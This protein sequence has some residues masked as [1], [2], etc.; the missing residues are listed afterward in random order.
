MSTPGAKILVI[1]RHHTPELCGEMANSRS[2]KG[3]YKMTV[4]SYAKKSRKC[5]NTVR[6]I[7]K[8]NKNNLERI[9]PAKLGTI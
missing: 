2:W 6:A 8:R 3:K 4:R 7:S 9:L 5:S 1:S